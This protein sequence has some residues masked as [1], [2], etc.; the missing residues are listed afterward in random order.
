MSDILERAAREVFG[1]ISRWAYR[2]TDRRSGPHPTTHDV[3]KEAA[4]AALLAALDP[5]D[6]ALIDRIEDTLTAGGLD[7]R[8]YDAKRVIIMLRA[9]AQG[10]QQ[11]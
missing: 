11:P 4:R 10:G 9:F 3:A 1:V 2:S 6:E 7:A 5:E 8:A